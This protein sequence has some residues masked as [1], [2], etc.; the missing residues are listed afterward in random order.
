MNDSLHG[1]KQLGRW[2]KQEAAETELLPGLEGQR[3]VLL[4]S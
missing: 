2:T 4:I 3:V 1:R